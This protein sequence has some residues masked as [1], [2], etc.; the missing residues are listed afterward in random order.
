MIYTTAHYFTKHC[1]V[2]AGYTECD[3]WREALGPNEPLLA[4]ADKSGALDAPDWLPAG[5]MKASKLCGPTAAVSP[6]EPSEWG[7]S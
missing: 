6:R 4:C 3:T 5:A 7:W 2:R 1:L